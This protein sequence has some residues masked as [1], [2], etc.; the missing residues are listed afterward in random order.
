MDTEMPREK[1]FTMR[2]N[3][4]ESATME[5][6][7]QKYG[8]TSAGVVRLLVAR[9]AQSGTGGGKE[10]D[11]LQNDDRAFDHV[12]VLRAIGGESATGGPAEKDDVVR[13]MAE[14]G[15]D[16]RWKGWKT[17]PRMLNELRRAGYARKVRTG[18]ELT[19]KGESALADWKGV[20]REP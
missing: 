2:I 1:L 4:E 8:L 10:V 15:Y 13:W 3:E 7:A 9:E 19:P 17:F 6:L 11:P 18:Y 16:N 20:M 12:M 14:A 5:S